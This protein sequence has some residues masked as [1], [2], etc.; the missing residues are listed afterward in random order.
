EIPV[1]FIS[2]SPDPGERVEG[3][4]LGAVDFVSK[5][6]Q[7]AELLARAG[8]HLELGRLRSQLEAEVA[9][10]TE[11]LRG[12][13]ASLQT[14]IVER[15]RTE[16]ALRESEER[17]RNM[18][19]NAPTMIVALGPDRLATFFNKGWLDF[20]GRSMEQELGAGWA[21]GVHPG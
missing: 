2:A 21:A 13:V 5:P 7:S 6:F 1:M 18:A 15:Q 17:F 3:L 16:R 10:R 9:K 12:T 4:A 11:E 14:E 20:T 8:T 19:D